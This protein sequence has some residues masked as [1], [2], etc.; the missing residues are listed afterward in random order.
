MGDKCFHIA[1]GDRIAQGVLNKI[2]QINWVEVDNLN[3]TDR[4][5]GFGST[6]K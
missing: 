2:E 1:Q 6:G 5:G 3:T 4:N